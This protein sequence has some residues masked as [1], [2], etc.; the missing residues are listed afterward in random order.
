MSEDNIIEFTNPAKP[1]V[2]DQ[3]TEFLRIKSYSQILCMEV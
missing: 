1:V 3:L 2:Q